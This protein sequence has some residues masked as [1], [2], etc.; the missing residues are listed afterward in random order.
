MSVPFWKRKEPPDTD[1]AHEG[2]HQENEQHALPVGIYIKPERTQDAEEVAE[3]YPLPVSVESTAPVDDL[4]TY[5]AVFSHA[6]VSGD[7]VVIFGVANKRIKLR[8]IGIVKPT[9]QQTC[10][11]I[12]RSSLD[13]GGTSTLAT[14]PPMES[15]DA[16]SATVRL[17]TAAPTA[18]TSVGTSRYAIVATGDVMIWSFDRPGVK[19][20]TLKRDDECLALNVDATGSIYGWLEWTEGAV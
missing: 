19:P 4:P 9:A 6:A 1:T 16:P 2:A 20:P 8:E 15:G 17:Y 10:T 12:K 11:L 3:G 5:S 14:I 18:G 13:T 7:S